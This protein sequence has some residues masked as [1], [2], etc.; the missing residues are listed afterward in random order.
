MII[1]KITSSILFRKQLQRIHQL[2]PSFLQIKIKCYILFIN[3][4]RDYLHAKTFRAHV[5]LKVF[6]M[7]PRSYK[8]KHLTGFSCKLLIV[9]Y[10]HYWFFHGYER[11]VMPK[12][13]HSFCYLNLKMLCRRLVRVE[14]M[15]TLAFSWTNWNVNFYW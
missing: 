11:Q 9:S 8:T 15:E 1:L 12:T 3:Y 5:S 14:S 2:S 6:Q 4:P 7:K 13:H 10:F